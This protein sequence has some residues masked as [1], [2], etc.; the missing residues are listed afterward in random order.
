V[1]QSTE[2]LLQVL[3]SN[4]NASFDDAQSLP[5]SIYHSPEIL[6][7]EK[8]Q[9]F[10]KEWICIGRTAEIPGKGDFLCRDII[11][12]PVFV[13]RQRDDSLKAFA[14]VCA[15]RSSRLLTGAGHVS[16]I[17]CPYHSWT[18]ELDGQLI[19][20]PFMDKTPGFDVAKHRLE[21]LAC[22]SWEGFIYVSLHSNPMPIDKQLSA[23]TDLVA[24][25]RM[26]DYVPVFATEETWNTN[27]KCLV[28][29]FMDAYH[30]H[31]VHKDSFGKHGSSEDQT[32]LFPGENTFTYHY[33]QEDGGP[34]SVHA[35]PDNTWLQGTDRLRTWL[36]NIFPSHTIQLQPDMLWYLSILPDGIGKVNI[37][38]AVS[39]PA[40]IL[41][42]AK[43]RQ[44]V[45]DEVM[46]LI[47]QV[48]GEDRPI[49]ENVFRS[50]ASPD[51]R[52]GP[53]SWLERNVWEFGRYLARHLAQ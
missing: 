28:E 25:F 24:D 15:H 43:V 53:L 23:L 37:R 13:I 41:D 18:Y 9:L 8:E 26:A 11:D 33:V 21:E 10:R 20:A 3:A 1:R 49:V 16:R 35:H 29:N 7:L 17:S 45:I 34:R 39:I 6:E 40:E 12:A 50:T 31:R 46:T 2:N 47:H 52:Q 5:P 32:Q 27:W 38:W 44:S 14:N 36:I 48:N 19:G 51:A 22:E 4:A 42:A 30:L